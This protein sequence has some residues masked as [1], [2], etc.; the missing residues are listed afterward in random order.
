MLFPPADASS[1]LSLIST[2]ITCTLLLYAWPRFDKSWA[3]NVSFVHA[4]Y[5]VANLTFNNSVEASFFASD[6]HIEDLLLL[7]P[8][9]WSF[10]YF[11]VSI[12]H[13]QKAVCLVSRTWR[14]F[15]IDLLNTFDAHTHGR[16]SLDLSAW[17]PCISCR[18][19]CQ[20]DRYSGDRSTDLAIVPGYRCQK[21]RR[22]IHCCLNARL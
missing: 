16:T 13:V 3:D 6:N 5:I 7:M 14:D 12:E 17:V 4:F 9:L 1:W 21:S 8:P 20:R 11:T 10:F 15:S 18:T 2:L 22:W 19:V